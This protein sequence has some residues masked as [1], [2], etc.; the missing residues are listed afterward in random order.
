MQIAEVLAVISS[1]KLRSKAKSSFLY[2]KRTFI[3]ETIYQQIKSG[4]YIRIIYV[5]YTSLIKLTTKYIFFRKHINNLTNHSLKSDYKYLYK[6]PSI[7]CMVHSCVIQVHVIHV[8]STHSLPIS[9]VLIQIKIIT[10]E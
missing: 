9:L 8:C 2:K 1:Q 5:L 7:N 10:F 6:I 3:E 4:T